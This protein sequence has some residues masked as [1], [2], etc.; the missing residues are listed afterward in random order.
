[1]SKS[2]VCQPNDMAGLD[3]SFKAQSGHLFLIYL[4]LKQHIQMCWMITT[5][6]EIVSYLSWPPWLKVGLS[7]GK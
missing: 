6:G 2:A 5:I 3:S 7:P 1:M 4:A